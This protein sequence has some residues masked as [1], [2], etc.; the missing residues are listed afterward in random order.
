MTDRDQGLDAADEATQAELTDE[1][2]YEANPADVVEEHEPVEA[3]PAGDPLAA[4]RGVGDPT[5]EAPE[6]DAIEQH[7]DLAPE[8]GEE[9]YAVTGRAPE[10]GEDLPDGVDAAD[11]ADQ[12]RTVAFDEDDYR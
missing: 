3:V 9:D 5:L 12:G 8:P 11:R 6:A 7:R 10:P 4:A 2:A 1:P